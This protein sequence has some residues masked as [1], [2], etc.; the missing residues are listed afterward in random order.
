M[1]ERLAALYQTHLFSAIDMRMS[2]GGG[3][4][5]VKAHGQLPKAVWP[6]GD[7]I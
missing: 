6:V 3:W 1:E 7:V 2:R 4:V 5:T